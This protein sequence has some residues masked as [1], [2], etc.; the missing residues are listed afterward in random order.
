MAQTIGTDIHDVYKPPADIFREH[1]RSKR[2][3]RGPYDSNQYTRYVELYLVN[4]YRTYD[5]HGKNS[6]VVFKRSQ[7]IANIVNSLYRQLNIYV[8]LVGVEVWGTGDKIKITSSADTTMENFLRYRKERINP[9]YPNDNAQLITGIFF[10]HGVVGKAIKGPICTHQFSGGVSMDYDG[11]VTLVATTVAH[12][13]GHNFGMEHDNDTK[14]SCPEDK[15]IMAATSGQI[16][17]HHWSSCSQNALHEAFELGMDY[18]LRNPPKMIFEGPVC[19]NGFVEEGEEC[20]CGLPK[21]C[22]NR[23]CNSTTCQL[24]AQA[25]CGTGRCCNMDT[26][27]PKTPSTLC[28]EPKGECD[29]PEFCDGANEFCPPDVYL[30]N[31]VSCG[32]GQSYCYKGKC[33]THNAQCQLLWGSTGRV[34]DP[35]CFQQLNIRGDHD[36]NCGYNWTTDRYQMCD[37]E[38]VMCGLLHCVHLNE[39][40]MFWRDNL[41]LD[42][43]ANFL[44]RGNTQYVCRSTMLDVGLDM[45]DPGLVPDGAKCED[46]KICINQACVP[47]MKLNIPECPDCHGNGVCNSK[48]HCHCHVGYR[49]PLCDRPGYGG[50]IDSGPA[51]NEYAK[52]DLLIGLLVLFLVILPL[53][54]LAFLA[55]INRNRLMTW[56]SKGPRIKF[57]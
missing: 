43:R 22:T 19:G 38:N 37:R 11:L 39:K 40:L 13:M 16:S 6:T 25:L 7:D 42:M 5:R 14:C 31:G 21:D 9:Y 33:N 20:D 4:D 17:P 12:E 45:P 26:C 41:A 44:M 34:S 49:P 55:Y 2:S 3:I 46:N 18:C 29:L 52:R 27:K 54:A 36:G 53:V 32:G 8:V 35:I 28:R 48:G 24:H 23:C 30:E 15:C 51:T 57:G 1:I 56:W 10:D 50:S 47:L